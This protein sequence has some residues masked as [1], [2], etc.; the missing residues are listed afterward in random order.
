MA[1]LCAAA[2]ATALGADVLVLEKT[3]QPGGSMLLSSGFV[4]RHREFDDFRRECPEGDESLQR[5]LFERLDAD[6]D[7]LEDLG[8]QVVTRDT[9]NPLTTG[10]RFD[11]GQLTQTL[12]GAAG[13]IRT[14]QPLSELP[15][16]TPVIL[17]TGGFQADRQ[18]VREHVTP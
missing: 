7:W 14:S 13:D 3:A 17:A 1:G 5:L 16:D 8:G 18:L 6:L 2:H 15:D 10:R 12:A 9:A 11:P 4:W